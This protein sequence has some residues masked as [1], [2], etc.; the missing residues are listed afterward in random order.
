MN[1]RIALLQMASCGTDVDAAQAKADGFCRQAKGLGA[2]IALFPEMFSIGYTACPSYNYQAAA[3]RSLSQ[4][5]T[6]TFVSHFRQLATELDMAITAT[7][8]EDQGGS[9]RNTVSLIDRQGDV[10]LTYAKVHTCE[11]AWESTLTP[12][13][14]F[15]V[16]DLGTARG[17]VKVG[18]MICF[19]REFP[20]SARALMLKGAEVILVPNA[21]GLEQHRIGQFKARAYENMA[22]VAMTNYPPPRANGHSVA[23]DGACFGEDGRVRDTLLVEADESEG[24]F[25]AEVDLGRLR[26]YRE[27]S[28]WA[29]A[30]RRPRM[31]GALTD[32]AVE[33]PFMRPKATR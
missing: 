20:E 33:E 15:Y 17:P 19:D 26:A 4:P 11:W 13:D 31:Y 22:A 3:W 24:V 21:C 5:V 12:G 10:R 8:L 1:L 6:G 30:Y 25:I 32:D 27:K 28:V 23:F 2:D 14:D 29:N 18:A 7:Y 9:M 16:C